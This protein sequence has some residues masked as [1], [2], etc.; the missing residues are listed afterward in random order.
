[1]PT[2]SVAAPSSRNG[3]RHAS[4]LPKTLVPRLSMFG[5]KTTA[6]VMPIERPVI[7]TPMPRLR[8]SRGVCSAI[9]LRSLE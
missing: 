4:A 8:F 9:R 1:M 5:A 7:T 2:V 6:I 3:I